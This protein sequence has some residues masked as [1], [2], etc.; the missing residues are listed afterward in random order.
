M[1]AALCFSYL[2]E[3]IAAPLF[4]RTLARTLRFLDKESEDRSRS[5]TNPED[6]KSRRDSPNI[7]GPADERREN[8]PDSNTQAEGNARCEPDVLAEKGL[9]QDN[10]CAIRRKKAEP[11]RQ[12]QECR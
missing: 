2:C 4:R 12:Q 1:H 5:R 10:N 3:T 6:L 9:P 7:G 11:D 8:T